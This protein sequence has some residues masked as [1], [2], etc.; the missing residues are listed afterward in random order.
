[1]CFFSWCFYDNR[2]FFLLWSDR[3][4]RVGHLVTLR[5]VSSAKKKKKKFLHY[6]SLEAGKIQGDGRKI[7]DSFKSY[8]VFGS[9]ISSQS[10]NEVYIYYL[11]ITAEIRN[12]RWVF[13]Y[14]FV[15]DCFELVSWIANGEWSQRGAARWAASLNK[16]WQLKTMENVQKKIAIWEDWVVSTIVLPRS[17]QRKRSHC[18]WETRSNVKGQHVPTGTDNQRQK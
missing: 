13:S 14:I 7:L 17:A 2:F 11:S 3:N 12:K 4:H 1:M 6:C 5:R 10:L 8:F 15:F 18:W 9:Q 16:L